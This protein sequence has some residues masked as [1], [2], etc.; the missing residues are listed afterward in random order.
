MKKVFLVLS[1]LF[2]LFLIPAN[3]SFSAPYV[4]G[5]VFDFDTGIGLA[6]VDIIFKPAYY[7]YGAHDYL[8]TTDFLG[9]YVIDPMLASTSTSGGAITWISYA[10]YVQKS[11]YLDFVGTPFTFPHFRDTTT[12]Q[13]VISPVEYDIPLQKSSAV[14]EPATMLLLGSGLLGMLFRR[15][16][17]A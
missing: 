5:K 11:G 8:T 9:D 15:K 10:P 3:N 14:P 4:W 16:S 13:W 7:A 17:I 12:Y 2:V 6:D 1:F